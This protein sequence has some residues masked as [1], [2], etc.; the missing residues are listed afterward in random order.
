MCEARRGGTTVDHFVL[1]DRRGCYLYFMF[2]YL[3][4]YLHIFVHLHAWLL[5]CIFVNKASFNKQTLV[6]CM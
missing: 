2:K 6:R 5:Y 4:C 1:K 3:M